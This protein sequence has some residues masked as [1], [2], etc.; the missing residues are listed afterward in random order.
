MSNSDKNGSERG[1]I[2]YLGRY[3]QSKLISYEDMVRR[4]SITP[5]DIDGFIDY[6]GRAFIW[7]EGKLIDKEMDFGQQLALEHLV[8]MARDAGRFACVIVF[9]FLEPEDTIIVAKNKYVYKS[10]D[11]ISLQWKEPKH[12]VTLL[13]Y[14][15]E[16]ENYC[17][18]KL[19]IQL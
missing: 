16:I 19:G 18:K 1:S 5:T 4:R 7:L 14:I 11:S 8:Q 12:P 15:I 9:H 2:K 3:K 13:Q 6:N 17:E 10:Y